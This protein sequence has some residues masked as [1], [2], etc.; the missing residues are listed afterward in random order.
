MVSVITPVLGLYAAAVGVKV[1][2]PSN[3][4]AKW[5]LGPEGPTSKVIVLLL[6]VRPLGVDD[7]NVWAPV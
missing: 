6:W 2:V 1:S 3:V 7:T 5:C 4:W